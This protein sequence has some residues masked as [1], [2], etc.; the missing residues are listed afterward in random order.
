MARVLIATAYHHILQHLATALKA[1]GHQVV[2]LVSAGA[3][4]VMEQYLEPLGCPHFALPLLAGE[5]NIGRGMRN[6]PEYAERVRASVA[7]LPELDA[8]FMVGWAIHVLPRFLLEMTPHPINVHPSDLPRYRGGFPLEAQI[9]AGERKFYVS[10][11]HTVPRIDAGQ[12]LARSQPMKIRRS[13]TMTQLLDRCLPVGAGLAASV[14]THWDS[15][16][17]VPPLPIED[18]VPHAWGLKRVVDAEGRR[19]NQGVLGRLRIEWTVDTAADIARSAKA[20]DMV[21]GAFTSRGPDVFHVTQV[22]LVDP[23]TSGALGEVL[24]VGDGTWDLQALDGVLRIQGR[25]A[26]ASH[27]ITVGERFDSAAPISRL[28]GF[29]DAER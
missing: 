22:Q 20:F 27:S 21:G 17:P 19:R 3:L 2:G 24:A 12:V 28:L 11:H 4:P 18:P 8:T 16:P 23:S 14:V 6:D 10:V 26:D 9:L 7:G 5:M 25:F 15:L 1:Q 29:Q 13:D